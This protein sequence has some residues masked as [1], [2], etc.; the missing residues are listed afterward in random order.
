[1]HQPESPCDT[2]LEPLDPT[3][4]KALIRSSMITEK[5]VIM[6]KDKKSSVLGRGDKE[7]GEAAAAS[8]ETKGDGEESEEEETP[9]K[10]PPPKK[11]TIRRMV[12]ILQLSF[13]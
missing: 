4:T 3:N 10:K 5:K 12:N 11:R 1:M 2:N 8:L 7:K 13:Y 6:S 9:P